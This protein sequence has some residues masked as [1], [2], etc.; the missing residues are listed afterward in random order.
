MPLFFFLSGVVCN[1]DKYSWRSFLKRRFNT[2]IIPYVFFYIL[3]YLIY[4][5]AERSFRD[6]DLSW[7]EPI[8]GMLYG[9]QWNGYMAHN[10][11]LWFLPCLFSVEIVYFVISQIRGPLQRF[12]I[13]FICFIVAYFI[14]SN[15]PW[16]VNIAF[17]SLP[18][19]CLGNKLKIHFGNL[20]VFGHK[21]LIIS[22]IAGISYCLIQYFTNNEVNMAT[23]HYG[24][25]FVFIFAA[26][27]GIFAIVYFSCYL[28]DLNFQ[29]SWIQFLGRNTLVIF[30]L[31]QPVLRV[32]RYAGYHLFTSINVENSIIQALIID[33]IV[34]ITL[35]PIIHLYNKYIKKFL[36]KLYIK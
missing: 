33:S 13:I 22:I 20:R 36:L 35:L 6:I 24:N 7:W 9:A 30:A 23:A 16:C 15:L 26:V 12:T 18:F 5:L 17:V 2:L 10:G 27:L 1:T 3:T 28:A 14:K 8:I 31:H 29:T 21:K 34:I 11:I 32:Y 19:F 4:L 25:M